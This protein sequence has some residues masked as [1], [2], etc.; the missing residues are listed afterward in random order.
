VLRAL[1]RR[2]AGLRGSRPSALLVPVEGLGLD[3]PADNGLPPH[4]TVLFPFVAAREAGAGLQP[5][6]EAAIGAF[7]AFD[8]ALTATGRFPGVLYLA[9]EPAAPFV[10]LTEACA[11]RWPDHP[12]YGGAYAE[13]IPHLTLAE[14]AEPP[15]L[16][17][18]VERRLPLRARAEELWL[19]A[20]GPDGRWRK[21]AAI[22]LSGSPR[23]R[24]R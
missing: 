3:P 17:D 13:V 24:S 16:A 14:G 10:A 19:M 18:R 5:E 12:P 2:A 15:G 1:R 9:P 23:S 8:F 20:P 11:Q 6:L 21:R 22:P 4:V 7:P